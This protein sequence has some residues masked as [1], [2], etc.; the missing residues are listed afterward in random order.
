MTR[1]QSGKV[2]FNF[3]INWVSFPAPLR[4]AGAKCA[5][6]FELSLLKIL[7]SLHTL[8]AN[9]LVSTLGR[10]PDPL[11]VRFILED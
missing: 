2:H 7:G 1:L 8:L 11:D 9:P 4:S 6:L 10:G 3:V 5:F